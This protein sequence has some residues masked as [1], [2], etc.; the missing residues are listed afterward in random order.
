MT[1]KPGSSSRTAIHWAGLIGGPV[2]AALC[3]ALLP[4]EYQDVQGQTL[5]FTA[6]GRRRW[7]RW[8]GWASGGWTE[9]LEIAV[10]ALLPLALFPLLGIAEMR[11]AAAPYANP[12]IFLF[13]GGFIPGPVDAAMGLGRRVA[14]ITLYVVGDP[15]GLHDRR[16]HAHHRGVQRVRLQHSHDGHDAAHCAEYDR[17]AE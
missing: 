15:A 12:L 11:A 3:Y 8:S 10:T 4:S 16:V 1:A 5:A 7:R 17:A 13:M 6:A 2:L 9:A 14:L